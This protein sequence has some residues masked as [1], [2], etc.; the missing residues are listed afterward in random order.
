MDDVY[1]L[2]IIEEYEKENPQPYFLNISYFPLYKT[3]PDARTVHSSDSFGNFKIDCVFHKIV[4]VTKIYK[5]ATHYYTYSGKLTSEGVIEFDV[6]DLKKGYI[7][8]HEVRLLAERFYPTP[9]KLCG[10]SKKWVLFLENLEKGALVGITNTHNVIV[11]EQVLN[12]EGNYKIFQNDI[13]TPHK[14]EKWKID[15]ECYSIEYLSTYEN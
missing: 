7:G 15:L 11:A 3:G 9:T 4:E 8:K 2:T 1:N 12:E 6:T 5:N 10:Y 13:D 14:A